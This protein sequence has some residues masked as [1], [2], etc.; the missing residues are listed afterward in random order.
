M[1]VTQIAQNK[2][3][4][5]LDRQDR[6]DHRKISD[7]LVKL[8]MLSVNQLAATIKLTEVW[9]SV[10]VEDYPIKLI[11]SKESKSEREVRMGTRRQFD[12][13]AKRKVSKVS[14]VFDAARLWNQAPQA[15]N[16]CNSLKSAKRAIKSYC[17]TL[18]I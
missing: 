17:K 1:K 7:M 4:R 14:F 12:E 16:N 11:K 6:K 5:L 8:D 10:N 15:I 2:V 9:K 13:S 3:L 18:P